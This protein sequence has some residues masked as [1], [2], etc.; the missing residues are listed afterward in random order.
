M[1]LFNTEAG[2]KETFEPIGDVVKMYVCG[3]TPKNDP[4]LGHARLFAVNDTVR[5]YLEYRGYTVRYIQ[6]FTDIDDKIIEAGLRDGIPAFEAA[7]RYTE[8]Y[9]AVMGRL[10]IR[11][12][13][14]FTY[15]TQYIPQIIAMVEGLIATGHAYAVD[16][17][18]FFSVPSFPAYGRLS[19]RDEKAM[20]VGARIEEDARKRDPR[21]F[22]LWKSAKPNEPWWESPWGHGRPGWHIECSTMAMH[23][24]GEQIDIHG[25]GSD[26]IFP[27]HENEIAQ[28]ESFTGKVP[29]VR[30]WLHTGMLS[31]PADDGDEPAPQAELDAE[32]VAETVAN[33]EGEGPGGLERSTQK[34]AHSGS[35]VTIASVLAAGDIPPM[36]LR[37]YLLGQQYRANLL[38][39]EEQLRASV[40]RW[41]RWAE[42]AAN[43]RR[44]GA[45]AAAERPGDEAAADPN[46][47]KRL[48]AARAE[49]IAAMDD[50]LNTSRALS[51]IDELAHRINDATS[52]LR[53]ETLT[54]ATAPT[55]RASLDTLTELAGVLGIALED[56][57]PG[58]ALSERERAAIE[59]LVRLRDLA[60]KEKHWAESDRIR[61]EL[62][63]RYHVTV[64]DTPQ[65]AVW[66]VKE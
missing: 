43:L 58:S 57:E 27:H 23:A 32:A 5:R 28:S 59:E 52:G 36:A 12:A 50:D 61:K 33:E 30:F 35:F 6:N 17:D 47:L 10:G 22:A 16:G 53:A 41:R 21:D 40:V 18:V 1:Q 62:D 3:L 45:W 48:E 39:S 64:K 26:L 19:G 34:M 65:G 25:G 8:A 55:L 37:T 20:R 56:E 38:Y 24:L 63:E 14:E 9:F 51:V 46:T 2:R 29:F 15:V 42:T 7:K 49:F 66:S 4:H 31:L 11:R 60:R 54:P 44:L 13:D